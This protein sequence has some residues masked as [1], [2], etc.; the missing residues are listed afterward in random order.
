MPFELSVSPV[1]LLAMWGGGIAIAAGLVAFWR[2]VGAG[3]L[4]TAGGSALLA[5]AAAFGAGPW[6]AAGVV[7][8]ACA[9][10]A[11]KW[12]L[13][14]GVLF[15][16]GG[17]ALV[18]SAIAG[19][20]DHALAAV[21]GAL[22]LGGTSSEMLLGH[23]YLVDP[24]L[25]RW[26]LRRLD[27]AGIVGLVADSALVVTT[28]VVTGAVGWTYLGL[29]LMSILMMVGVWFSLKEHGYEGVMAATGLSYLSVLT[30][31]GTIALGRFL[32]A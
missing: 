16:L 30:A 7:L 4:W 17:S 28:G 14:A 19:S 22:A 18:G 25:P 2:V 8:V 23:W 20:T 21:T 29:V 5:G 12:W 9:I 13:P 1:D 15:V 10:I 26:A 31:L 6:G 32:L 11:A 27:G 3:F 24:K